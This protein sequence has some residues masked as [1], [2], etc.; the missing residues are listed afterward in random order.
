MFLAFHSYKTKW[1][2][3]LIQSDELCHLFRHVKQFATP[4]AG[5]KNINKLY[6]SLTKEDCD[7]RL[8]D[9]SLICGDVWVERWNS[10]SK[11]VLQMFLRPKYVYQGKTRFSLSIRR[12]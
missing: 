2:P 1:P 6:G 3:F 5:C 4:Y 10:T 11:Y 12:T 9:L 8:L 7:F